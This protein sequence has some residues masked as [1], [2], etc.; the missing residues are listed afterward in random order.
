MKKLLDADGLP[1]FQFDE[2]EAESMA[3]AIANMV[4]TDVRA[5]D[6]TLVGFDISTREA[7]A[8]QASTI[9]AAARKIS[10]SE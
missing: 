6:G 7:A 2:G 5:S 4:V 9:P 1:Y 3:S 8:D 10:E